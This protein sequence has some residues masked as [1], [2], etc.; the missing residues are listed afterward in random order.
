MYYLIAMKRNF[1]H[2]KHIYKHK[3]NR[4]WTRKIGGAPIEYSLKAINHYYN[5]E[6]NK[7]FPEDL[8]YP[9]NGEFVV[10]K[11]FQVT[12]SKKSK[13][14]GYVIQLV[15]KV[16]DAY[17]IKKNKNKGIED[18]VEKIENISEFTSGYANYMND[19]YFELFFI[20]DGESV[21]GDNFQNGPILLYTANPN[22]AT[23]IG[24]DDEIPTK[25][26]IKVT[27][28]SWFIPGVQKDVKALYNAIN[29]RMNINNKNSNT[30]NI[31]GLNWSLNPNTPANG[32]PYI[33]DEKSKEIIELGRVSN[34][35]EHNVIVKW[36]ITKSKGKT[37]ISSTF[38]SYE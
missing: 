32:L 30:I 8:R 3:H 2:H 19:S 33:D 6:Y 4:S 34:V 26:T 17:T 37:S 22:N 13:V 16:T 23:D 1:T 11:A 36:D 14:Y 31:L 24:P 10:H 21:Y 12:P 9:V 15:Q 28:T 29:S 27:G 25:G 5:E 18:K 7:H 35:L 38:K 20:M